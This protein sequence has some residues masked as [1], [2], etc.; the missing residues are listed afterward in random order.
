MNFDSLILFSLLLLT[1]I[2]CGRGYKVGGSGKAVKA[3]P[4]AEA[5]GGGGVNTIKTLMKNKRSKQS[6]PEKEAPVSVY[7][8]PLD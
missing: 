8:E 3:I 2:T 5:G 1:I 7:Q 4:R 6:Q